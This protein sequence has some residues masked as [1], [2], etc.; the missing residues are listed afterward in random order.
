M[1]RIFSSSYL[2]PVALLMFLFLLQ[3]APPPVIG[4]E[5]LPFPSS[6]SKQQR[7]RAVEPP[8][9]LAEYRATLDPLNCPQLSTVRQN[10]LDKIESTPSNR[11][12]YFSLLNVLEQV[13]EDK[14]CQAQK[15]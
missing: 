10:I 7:Q 9:Y 11:T 1:N 13:R 3:A 8:A 15:K 4:A 14:N 2:L 5:L 6:V 12:Y